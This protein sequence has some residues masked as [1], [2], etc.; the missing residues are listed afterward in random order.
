MNAQQVGEDLRDLDSSRVQ[1]ASAASRP[2]P[3]TPSIAVLP[4]TNLSPEAE[5]AYFADG[6]T[7]DIINA[8]GQLK[9]LRVAAR[10][11]SFAFKG[12]TPELSEVGA[13][14]NV[15]TILNGSF[16]RSGRRVRIVVELVNVDDGFQLWSERYDRE[17]DDVFVIQQKHSRRKSLAKPQGQGRVAYLRFTLRA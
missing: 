8:L 12:R 14:L 9:A 11:S 5:N 16:R 17:A 1:P 4:F 13:K 6:I 7:E 15:A 2:A 3:V 10:T